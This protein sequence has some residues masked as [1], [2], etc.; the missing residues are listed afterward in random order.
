[1]KYPSDK[2]KV[3]E[4]LNDG[5]YDGLGTHTLISDQTPVVTLPDKQTA[6]PVEFIL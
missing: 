3:P 5:Q 2:L 1:M 4:K 6:L